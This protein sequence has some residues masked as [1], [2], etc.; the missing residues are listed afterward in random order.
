MEISWRILLWGRWKED[1]IV[2]HIEKKP[3]HISGQTYQ[4]DWV[5]YRNWKIYHILSK[6]NGSEF[7]QI[8]E[9]ECEKAEYCDLKCLILVLF[10]KIIS[11][12]REESEDKWALY[13]QLW[14]D[15]RSNRRVCQTSSSVLQTNSSKYK[16][17][18]LKHSTQTS[19]ND[20]KNARMY[21]QGNDRNTKSNMNQ[22]KK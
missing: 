3:S 21:S 19:P 5:N 20:Y 22:S 1:N 10:L 8:D 4:A 18:N 12:Y 2:D 14:F 17:W 11:N 9:W 7:V 15:S 16:W 13:Q 6:Q